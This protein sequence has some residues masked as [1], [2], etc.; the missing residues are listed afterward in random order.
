MSSAVL[1]RVYWDRGKIRYLN[2][3]EFEERIREEWEKGMIEVHLYRLLS[4]RYVFSLNI[5][6]EMEESRWLDGQNY[7][8]KNCRGFTLGREV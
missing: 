2:N 1:N 7:I 4:G 3:G 6:G 8:E 5:L